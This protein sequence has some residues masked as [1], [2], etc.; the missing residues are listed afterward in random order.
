MAISTDNTWL[1]VPVVI[2]Q[3]TDCLTYSEHCLPIGHSKIL[4]MQTTTLHVPPNL[5]DEKLPQL[6]IL[7]PALQET[8]FEGIIFLSRERKG[9]GICLLRECGWKDAFG[10]GDRINVETVETRETI[11]RSLIG[12]HSL[13][14][15][16]GKPALYQVFDRL[17]GRAIWKHVVG[18]CMKTLIFLERHFYV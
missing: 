9:F 12:K 10:Q 3:E 6:T 11:E 2:L 13:G 4:P 1:H 15:P 7:G 17:A 14:R 18:I 5:H 16:R 8:P